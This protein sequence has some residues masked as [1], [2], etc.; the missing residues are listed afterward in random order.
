MPETIYN[1]IKMSGRCQCPI[2]VTVLH[3][4]WLEN[5][6]HIRT[7]DLLENS[8]KWGTD[9]ECDAFVHIEE[10]LNKSSGIYAHTADL[11]HVIELDGRSIF[12]VSS[13]YAEFSLPVVRRQL[14]QHK[15]KL[16]YW[17]EGILCRQT[18]T[19]SMRY[20]Q[21][22]V[23]GALKRHFGDFVRASIVHNFREKYAKYLSA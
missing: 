6:S 14:C 9:G 18:C 10:P 7:S 21:V 3:R 19:Q 1:Y 4:I 23:T 11:L 17:N 20:D 15:C 22:A 2:H 12:A 8:D 13:I 5:R 16:F